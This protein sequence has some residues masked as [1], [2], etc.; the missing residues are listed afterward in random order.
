MADHSLPLLTSPYVD[1][2]A[3]LKSR[4]DDALVALD[5]AATTAT[6]FPTKSM[7]FSSAAAKWQTY[8]G[9]SWV[10][11]AAAYAINVSGNAATA[12]KLAAA[13]AINGTNFDG[14]AAITV[15]TANALTLSSAGDGAASGIT[16]NGSAARVISYNSVGAPSV[17]GAN[18]TGTWGIS[19]TGNAGSVTN[20]VYSSSSYSNPTWITTLAGSKITG[21]VPAATVVT[22]GVYTVGDQSIA[23][24][25]SFTGVTGLTSVVE[26]VYDIASGVNLNPANGTV[27]TKTITAVTGFVESFAAGQSIILMLTNGNQYTVTW[28]PMTWVRTVGN[29][30]P[31]L[32][33]ADTIILWKVG[34]TLYG[35]YVGSGA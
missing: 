12:T 22:N 29:V 24:N 13:V 7:R 18:A 27:Q 23:G 31:T 3:Y 9:S 8:N 6:N 32:T 34:T 35:S 16:F 10:D 4:I 5:P 21:T 14:S 1:Y 25:K 17:A 15:N 19:V 2:T 33:V 28:P 26:T 30:A 20:G 11:S